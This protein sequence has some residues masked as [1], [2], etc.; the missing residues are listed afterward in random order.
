MPAVTSYYF[1]VT[2]ESIECATTT[3]TR[4]FWFG[5]VKQMENGTACTTQSNKKPNWMWIISSSQ[6]MQLF[7]MRTAPSTF[8]IVRLFVKRIWNFNTALLS[9]LDMLI[10]III[11][12]RNF[13]HVFYL[14]IVSIPNAEWECSCAAADWIFIELFFLQTMEVHIYTSVTKNTMQVVAPAQHMY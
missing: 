6:H 3:P 7:L 12:F 1:I 14:F 9:A 8:I 4:R 5:F 2:Y 10:I 11:Y 13:F